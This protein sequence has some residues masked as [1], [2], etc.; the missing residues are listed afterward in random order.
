MEWAC[1][2]LHSAMLRRRLRRGGR[3]GGLADEFGCNLSVLS[4]PVTGAGA[5]QAFIELLR[6][7]LRRVEDDD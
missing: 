7:N 6:K 1:C 5:V 4:E 3:I 2:T